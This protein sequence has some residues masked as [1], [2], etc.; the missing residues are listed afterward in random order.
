MPPVT[1]AEKL[2]RSTL[3]KI[4]R[5]L[6]ASSDKNTTEWEG[7]LLNDLKERLTE[8]GRAFG[9]PEKGDLAQPLSVLQAY[10]INEIRREMKLRDKIGMK[11]ARRQV[12]NKKRFG[13]RA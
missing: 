13:G 11:K 5:Q 10:K 2:V 9:D 12:F 1:P 8:H 6:R 4:E 3:R 7:D